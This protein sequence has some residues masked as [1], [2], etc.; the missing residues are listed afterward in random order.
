MTLRPRGGLIRSPQSPGD[1]TSCSH[2]VCS[3]P[4]Q[5]RL[6]QCKDSES[7]SFVLF[8][9]LAGPFWLSGENS[10]YEPLLRRWRIL[11][12]CSR[13][14]QRGYL[15]LLL[16]S[17]RLPW[18][19]DWSSTNHTKLEVSSGP[20]LCVQFFPGGQVTAGHLQD[21]ASFDHV[22][23]MYGWVFSRFFPSFVF[24][25]ILR[26]YC[27]MSIFWLLYFFLKWKCPSE[28]IPQHPQDLHG[29]PA[30]QPHHLGV[31][32][33][34]TCTCTHR[35]GSRILVRGAQRSFEGDLNPKFAQNRVFLSKIAWKLHDFEQNLGGKGARPLGPPGSASG[36]PLTIVWLINTWSSD[37]Y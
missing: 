24:D 17:V 6:H 14:H 15:F 22:S 4:Q 5:T 21:T 10:G 32:S 25:S 9:A 37:P 8:S 16:F 11:C 7:L 27:C 3:F 35:E 29:Q 36:T 12:V 30:E 34:H 20:N 2:P 18:Y 26:W 33:G 13:P 19:M 28:Q 1:L 23:F 31:A